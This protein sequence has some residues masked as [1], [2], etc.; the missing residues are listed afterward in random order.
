[1]TVECFCRGVNVI[2]KERCKMYWICKL[3][4]S[5]TTVKSIGYGNCVEG[6]EE[7]VRSSREWGGG[8]CRVRE[9]A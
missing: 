1:M 4:H 9:R 8:V 7:M 6:R 3:H 5:D 2:W